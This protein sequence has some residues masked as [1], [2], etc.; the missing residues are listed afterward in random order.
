MLLNAMLKH[1]QAIN[2][3]IIGSLVVGKVN[4]G[5][6]DSRAIPNLTNP[7]SVFRSAVCRSGG[8]PKNKR[9]LKRHKETNRNIKET[10]R[11]I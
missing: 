3:V 10:N 1:L 2:K 4:R 8:T 5:Y 9:D 6:Q 11:N 7:V